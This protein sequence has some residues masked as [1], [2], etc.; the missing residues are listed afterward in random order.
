MTELKRHTS[1]KEE[2]ERW[3][4]DLA[5]E[6]SSVSVNENDDGT[7]TVIVNGKGQD[8]MPP[9]EKKAKSQEEAERWAAD[10]ELECTDVK[11]IDNRDGTWTVKANCP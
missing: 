11:V 3:A 4:A 9:V 2:A 10:L 1:S 6:S 7:W 8:E 5:F